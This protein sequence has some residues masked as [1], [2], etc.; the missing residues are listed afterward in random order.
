LLYIGITMDPPGRF[1]SHRDEKEWWAQVVGI[2]VESYENREELAAAERR[3]IQIERPVHNIVH[4]K[5][6]ATAR[7]APATVQ[8]GSRITY[9]CNSCG[10]AVTKG[11]GYIH[12]SY[13]DMH[14]VRE[15]WKALKLKKIANGDVYPDDHSDFLTPGIS[16]QAAERMRTGATVLNGC[17]MYTG[18]ELMELPD[19]ARWRVHHADCDP[20]PDGQDYH[21]DVARADTHEKLLSWT[22]HLLEKTWIQD[23]NWSEFLYSKISKAA[24]SI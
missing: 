24:M 17:F 16:P 20:D 3:A 18:A 8:P 1:R 19:A 6:A 4:K 9:Y 2:T 7:R 12:V 15:A 11:T 13:S 23:T 21:F 10:N 22:A 5:R 14:N